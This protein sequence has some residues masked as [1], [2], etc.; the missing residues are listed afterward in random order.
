MEWKLSELT[1]SSITGPFSQPLCIITWWP[2][3]SFQVLFKHA[4]CI[5]V[6][7]F[8]WLCVSADSTPLQVREIQQQGFNRQGF[9]ASFSKVSGGGSPG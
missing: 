9:A 6:G 1:H 4:S 2:L 8:A 3:L 5:G 7:S